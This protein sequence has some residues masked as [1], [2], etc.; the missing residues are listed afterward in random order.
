MTSPPS[1][2]RRKARQVRLH[3]GAVVEIRRLA[4]NDYDAVVWLAETL[5]DRERYLRFFQVHPRALDE[6]AHSVTSPA[7]NTVAMGVFESGELIGVGNYTT[8]DI[9]GSAE[10][11]VVVAHQQ[12]ERGVGTALLRALGKHARRRGVRRFVADVLAENHLMLK[13]LS[14]GDWACT[15]HLDGPVFRIEMA[16]LTGAE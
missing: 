1:G 16:L 7:K 12:H 9:P 8:T 15:R 14:D 2:S 11:A 5:T 10:I 4:T 6:W 3:D 13:V